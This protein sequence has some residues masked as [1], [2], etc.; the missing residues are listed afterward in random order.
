MDTSSDTTIKIGSWTFTLT[1]AS[2]TPD[3]DSSSFREEHSVKNSLDLLNG[4]QDA[5]LPQ[6]VKGIRTEYDSAYA[7]RGAFDQDIIDEILP[8]VDTEDKL[9]KLVTPLNAN[10]F[11]TEKDGSHFI[12]LE[13]NCTWDDEHGIGILIHNDRVL[14]HGGADVS[15]TEWMAKEQEA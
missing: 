7:D 2:E 10:V 6:I 5:L 4:N 11:K 15:F 3:F 12:G 1:F 14:K 9:L 8:A 13:F